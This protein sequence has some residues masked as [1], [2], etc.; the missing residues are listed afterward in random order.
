V[1][2][3]TGSVGIGPNAT[4]PISTLHIDKTTQTI[5]GTT[6]NGAL[7]I[8]GLSYG[9]YALELGTDG[10][11]VPFIQSRNASTTTTY[12]LALNPSGGNVGIG[13]TSPTVV[14]VEGV[15]PPKPNLN[16]ALSDTSIPCI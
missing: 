8:T 15:D 7:V 11:A 12:N 1:Y 4:T 16:I 10:A 13:T 14:R 2:R 5:G 9:N 3:S 6:P